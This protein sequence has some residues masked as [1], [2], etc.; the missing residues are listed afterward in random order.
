MASLKSFEINRAHLEDD[1]GM[2]KHFTTFAGIDY[3]RAGAP[4][5]EIVSYL[6]FIAQRGRRLCPRGSIDHALSRCFR[7]QY[8]RGLAAFRCQRLGPP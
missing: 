5:I 3:N 8:G 1:A 2:L 7:L 6:A 4:L